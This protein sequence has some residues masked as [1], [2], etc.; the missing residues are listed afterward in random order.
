ME[1]AL[2]DS[3]DRGCASTADLAKRHAMQYSLTEAQCRTYFEKNLHFYLDDRMIE[4][5]R[6]FE[7][8][9]RRWCPE[10]IPAESLAGMESSPT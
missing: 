6:C 9:V 1:R 10:L 8:M 7:Q 3:R 2:E 4:G 5:L